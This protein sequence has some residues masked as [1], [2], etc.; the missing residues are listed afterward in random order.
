[1]EIHVTWAH[2]P[3]VYPPY[4]ILDFST[5]LPI[6]IVIWRVHRGAPLEAT[7]G[8]ATFLNFLPSLQLTLG[9][10]G[11]FNASESSFNADVAE[12]ESSSFDRLYG[13]QCIGEILI[14]VCC[15]K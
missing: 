1:M 15:Q 11:N 5:T 7:S 14:G 3:S 10:T 12:G 13:A 8:S 6:S 4:E 2:F 9:T